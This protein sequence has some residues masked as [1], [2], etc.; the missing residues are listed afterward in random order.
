MLLTK[1]KTATVVPL[2]AALACCGISAMPPSV[3]NDEPGQ[4][5]TTA[6]RLVPDHLRGSLAKDEPQA[7]YAAD[8]ADPWNRI[9]YSLY[10]RTLQVRLSDDFP[11]G[12]PFD[13]PTRKAN[14][15]RSQEP[16]S[17]KLFERIES[18]DRAID[19]LYPSSPN[20]F[21]TA[22]DEANRVMKEPQ[23]SPLKKSLEDA[24]DEKT[25]R[26]P[27][28]RALMQSDL[29]AAHDIFARNYNYKGDE[30]ELRRE[31]REQ[32]LGLHVQL[33]KKLAL[34][35][36]EIKALPDNYAAAVEK[37]QLPNVFDT[38]GEWLEVRIKKDRFHD[39]HMDYR[40]VARVFV[41]PANSPQDKVSFLNSL[42]GDKNARE[43]LDAAVLMIQDLLIDSNGELV[44]SPLTFKVQIRTFV[45]GEGEKAVKSEAKQ[46][47]RSRQRLLNAPHG[48]GFDVFDEQS[49]AYRQGAGNNLSLAP[50]NSRSPN[51]ILIRLGNHCVYCHRR[52]EVVI[53][54]DTN[55]IRTKPT[56]TLAIL[57]ASDN[58][59][60]RYVIEQKSE[61]KDFKALVERWK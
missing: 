7:V 15:G 32:L 23:F 30:G 53:T 41:K 34:T 10:T 5:T 4:K 24:L 3:G 52:H 17:T 55:W 20:S 56:P 39:F 13:P 2:V 58:E 50:T 8:P 35:S 46:Y 25:N 22:G 12:K 21:T 47:E 19:P 36:D 27:L 42:I 54:F 44:A 60:A 49:P 28:A 29:W 61:R 18:G 9:S 51:P 33:I 40:R 38:N 37:G 16:V 48:S 45:K 14:D 1:L 43:K 31:R 6:E 59:H 26:S 57:K 11:D